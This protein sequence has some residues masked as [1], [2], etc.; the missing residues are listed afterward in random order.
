[1][2]ASIIVSAH[3]AAAT[4]LQTLESLLNQT[5]RD[6][7]IIVVDDGSTDATRRLAEACCVDQRLRVV[8][9]SYRGAAGARNTGISLARGRFVGF[10]DAGDQ[11]QPQKLATH[12][13]HLGSNL[14]IG[15]SYSGAD[16]IDEN[17]CPFGQAEQPKLRNVSPAHLFRRN[18]VGTVSS[19]LARREALDD[20]CYRPHTEN[21]RD[22]VFDEQ[23][24]GYEDFECWLRLAMTTTWKIEGVPG[25]LTRKRMSTRRTSDRFANQIAAWERMMTA[26]RPTNPGFFA[27]FEPAARAHQ[28]EF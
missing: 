24:K 26:L 10:C 23:L 8:H 27:Q 4:L 14:N 9:Q 18:P 22:W 15:L 1:P 20:L 19:V 3:N 12:V 16:M 17:N 5:Y 21:D 2:Q 6:F 28:F 7:E 11:W 13:Q 25:L